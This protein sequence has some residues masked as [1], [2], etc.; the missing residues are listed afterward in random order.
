MGI[1]P[2]RIL[3]ICTGAGGLDLGVGMALGSSRVVVCVEHEAT[4]IEV[5][6]TRMEEGWLDAAPI[7]SDLCTFDGQPWR[8]LVEGIVGGYPCQPF[9]LAG[10]QRGTEDPRHLWPNVARIIRECQPEWCF[11]ENVPNHLR[12]GYFDCVRPELEREGYSVKEGIFS[13]EEVG[14]PHR[15]ERMFVL[16][17]RGSDVAQRLSAGLQGGTG[18]TEAIPADAPSGRGSRVGLPPFPPG[19]SDLEVWERVLEADVW[20]APSI[21]QD[22][23]R[24]A[25]GVAAR[26]DI[27]SAARIRITGNG[28]VPQ[29]AELAFRTLTRKFA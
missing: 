26:L 22:V 10:K 4:A 9:S 19:P 25:D 20:L 2:E 24:M 5:L 11:F 18:S 12:V 29:V 1:H 8:G 23:L 13:A 17:V 28:V 16:A 21:K 14:A 6:A 7:W 15:R 3:S 27:P